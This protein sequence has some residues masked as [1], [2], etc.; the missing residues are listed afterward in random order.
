MPIT[1]YNFGVPGKVTVSSRINGPSFDLVG[2]TCSAGVTTAGTC[3]LQVQFNPAGPGSHT[4]IL[5]LT[6]S[7]GA[8]SSTVYLRGSKTFQIDGRWCLH[9]RSTVDPPITSAAVFLV[10]N[11]GLLERSN[12][13]C[14]L[15]SPEPKK[16]GVPPKSPPQFVSMP[17]QTYRY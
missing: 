1:I 15:G 5:T 11:R 4:D 2:S 12:G 10:R 7:V 9:P 16:A 3:T 6:P 13:T 17:K 14:R 8:A